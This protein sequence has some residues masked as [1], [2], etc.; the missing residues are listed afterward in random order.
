MKRNTSRTM[1]RMARDVVEYDDARHG[2][3]GEHHL[4]LAAATGLAVSALLAP[5]SSSAALRGLAAGALFMRALGGRQGVREWLQVREFRPSI[6]LS[7]EEVRA[8]WVL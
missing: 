1:Q 4:V 7:P 6:P 5:N 3:V 2:F 8:T